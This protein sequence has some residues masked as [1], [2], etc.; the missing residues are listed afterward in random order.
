MERSRDGWVTWFLFTALTAIWGASFLFIKIALET[1]PPL[2]I[3]ALR[4]T[5]GALLVWGFVLVQ[6]LSVTDIP[7]GH[8]V[9]VGLTNNALPFMLITW[10]EQYIPSGLASLLNGAM[11][12]F[13]ALLSYVWLRAERLNRLQWSGVFLGFVGMAWL[14]LPDAWRA[15][16]GLDTWYG[17]LAQLAT[18]LAALCYAVGTVYARRYLRNCDPFLSAAAQ[19]SVGTVVL[20]P[21]AFL[22]GPGL[23]AAALSPRT[24]LAVGWLGLAS[25]GLAYVIYYGLLR[26]IGATQIAM[27][28]YTIPV[29]G[30]ILG[31]VVLGEPIHVNV[32][33]AL[34]L[35]LT[36]ILLVNRKPRPAS[37][38]LPSGK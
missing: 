30:L 2:T 8:M 11:P 33:V 22:A 31:A 12:I 20:W 26:R 6:R 38:P 17:V 18:V 13:T 15:W 23:T 37:Q 4:L 28:T 36:G 10:G 9:F 27:V 35:I 16:Q 25:S 29:V 14:F 32:I 5:L 34:G 19:L 7:W 24:L 1:L 21:L 3:V